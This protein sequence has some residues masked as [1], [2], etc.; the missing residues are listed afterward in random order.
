MNC[1][2]DINHIG[3]QFI[4]QLRIRQKNVLLLIQPAYTTLNI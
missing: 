2:N 1:T 3:T 4:K